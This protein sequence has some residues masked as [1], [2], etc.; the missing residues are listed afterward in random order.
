LHGY[1]LP[2]LASNQF[3]NNHLEILAI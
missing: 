1:F 3:I 2:Y